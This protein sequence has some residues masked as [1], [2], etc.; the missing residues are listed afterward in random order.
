MHRRIP[1]A[2]FCGCLLLAALG[3]AAPADRAPDTVVVTRVQGELA[4]SMIATMDRAVRRAESENA[5]ALIVEIDTLGGE[6]SVMDRIAAALDRSKVVPT[7]YVLNEC[8]SAGAFIAM[9]G[10]KIYTNEHAQIGSSKPIIAPFGLPLPASSIDPEIAEK[11]MSYVR[12]KF[13][14][15]AQSHDKP[16]MAAI[17]QAMVDQ[18]I[19]LLLVQRG[20]D[21]LAMTREEYDDAVRSSPGSVTIVQVLDTKDRLL[22]LTAKEALDLGF[23][24]GIVASREDLLKTMGLDG[25]RVIEVLPSWS[26]HFVEFVEKIRWLLLGVGILLLIVEMKLPG[27]GICG[28]LGTAF[29]ALFLFHNWLIGLAEVQ[30]ILLVGLGL[31]LIAVELFVMPGTLIAGVAGVI[32]VLAGI[33]LSCL[34]FVLPANPGDS[35]LL[36][37]TLVDFSL[38]MFASA[39]GA[40]LL[41]R[42]ILPRTPIFKRLM[43]HTSNATVPGAWLDARADGAGQEARLAPGESAVASS[44]LRPAGKIDAAGRV[45]DAQSD[46]EWIAAGT[47]VRVVRVEAS[48]VIVRSDRE[49]GGA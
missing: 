3:F 29:V 41:S 45:F 37:G 33:V 5:A 38:S 15:R 12:S 21:R 34:P 17:A 36:H 9:A 30:E 44:D 8:V 47:R 20:R 49:A 19:E 40:Y 6:I 46:G 22:N 1:I 23:T 35:E 11:M 39:L 16:G 2:P 10:E 43:L 14:D 27:F 13:R 48:R 31:V 24:D 42:Y 25:A 18:S 26:E 4:E 32:C 7:T 28:I